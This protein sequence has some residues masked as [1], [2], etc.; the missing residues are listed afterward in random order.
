MKISPRS[1][2][3]LSLLI[4]AIS[5][6]SSPV[7]AQERVISWPTHSNQTQMKERG[8]EAFAKADL[9]AV[10]I[11]EFKVAGM[12]V[13]PGHRFFAGDDWLKGLTV[14]VK[15]ISD[16]PASAIRVMFAFPES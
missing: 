3:L 4:L 6:L 10:E 8:G 13:I 11:I 2:L 12:P 7:S 1:L 9:E 16:R 14:R 15:N 5:A